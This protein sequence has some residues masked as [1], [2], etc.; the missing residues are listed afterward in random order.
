[1]PTEEGVLDPQTRGSRQPARA[2]DTTH[3]A[4]EPNEEPEV[5]GRILEGVPIGVN[6]SGRPPEATEDDHDP[7]CCSRQRRGRG[8]DLSTGS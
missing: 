7:R 8:C 6:A 3:P 5:P 1:M 4:L 2:R